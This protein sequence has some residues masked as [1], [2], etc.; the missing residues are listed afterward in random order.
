MIP[1][2]HVVPKPGMLSSNFSGNNSRRNSIDT[3]VNTYQSQVSK[4]GSRPSQ[5][6]TTSNSS[7]EAKLTAA[8]RQIKELEMETANYYADEPQ[9]QNILAYFLS[10]ITI[11]CILLC[12][13]GAY[14]FTGA[15]YTAPSHSFSMD[16]IFHLFNTKGLFKREDFVDTEFFTNT[17][18]IGQNTDC[19]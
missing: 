3:S 6:N 17:K 15:T 2:I 7:S 16:E 12:V 14:K 1:V 11:S 9:T 18:G 4:H 13:F 8:A 19:R 5:S 10:F